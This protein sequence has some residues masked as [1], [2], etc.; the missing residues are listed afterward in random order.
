[1]FEKSWHSLNDGAAHGLEA[2]LI[3]CQW[4][5]IYFPSTLS[6]PQI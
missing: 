2:P 5:F 6:H 1:M 3:W 4:P